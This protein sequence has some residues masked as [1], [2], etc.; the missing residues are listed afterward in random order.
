MLDGRTTVSPILVRSY[1]FW[2]L[3]FLG[4]NTPFAPRMTPSTKKALFTAALH[5][6]SQWADRKAGK[7]EN[8]QRLILPDS[9]DRVKLI[10]SL[11]VKYLMT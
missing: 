7:A 5:A 4:A 11:T 6:A 9:P 2:A 8:H 3:P 10:I 1:D